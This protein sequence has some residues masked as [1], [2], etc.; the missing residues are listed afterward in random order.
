MH[1]CQKLFAMI[2][3][4]VLALI[5]VNAIA[6]PNNHAGIWISH[7]EIAQLPMS[8]S[9][10]NRLKSDADA[11][12]RSSP[13]LSERAREGIQVLAKALVYAKT[14]NESYRQEVVNA[15]MDVMGTEGGDALATFRALGTYV[16]CADLVGLPPDK[17]QN[18]RA[19]LRQLLDINNEV[20]SRSLVSTHEV[21]KANNWGT[22]AGFSRAAAAVY[23][24]STDG[25]GEFLRVAQVFKGWLGDQSSYIFPEG[26]FGDLSWQCDP[27]K[28]VGV[29]PKGCTK[30]GHL[31]DGVLP[32]DQ[33]RGG[34]FG[35]PPPKENYVYTG[36]QGVVPTAVILY[37]A[38]MIDVWDW[39]D[40]AILRAF[41][42]AYNVADFPAT[43]SDDRWMTWLI[44][45]YYGTNGRFQ[46]GQSAACCG[47]TMD[48]TDWTHSRNGFDSAP[49][50]PRNVRIL[51]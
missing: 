20:G 43:D 40:K 15:V 6:G 46:N 4:I 29:N 37:R 48:W 42:W 38:G 11:P 18:F 10:W 32:D 47:K 17:D 34:G 41:E 8:G 9:A 22:A 1:Q 33:R 51:N 25:D 27:Q 28:P 30:Q 13:N 39:Q 31:I 21:E 24:R 2:L 12:L 35:W 16:I 7:S 3:F 45:Y 49:I 36:L 19:W 14:G 44:D 23:L 50:P 5:P 26:A